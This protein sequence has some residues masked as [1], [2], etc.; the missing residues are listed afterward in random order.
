MEYY[1]LRRFCTGGSLN[2]SQRG[3]AVNLNFHTEMHFIKGFNKTVE[4]P[5]GVQE[6]FSGISQM[7]EPYM[8]GNNCFNDQIK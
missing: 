5:R 7:P 2:P 8:R 6:D 1:S 3:V 4:S